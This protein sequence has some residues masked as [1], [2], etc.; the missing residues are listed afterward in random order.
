MFK[1]KSEYLTKALTCILNRSKLS[2]CESNH[3]HYYHFLFKNDTISTLRGMPFF[4]LLS[5]YS[6]YRGEEIFENN[7]IDC[8]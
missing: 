2:V 3:H 1:L 5:S 8:V 4:K 6:R 7:Q